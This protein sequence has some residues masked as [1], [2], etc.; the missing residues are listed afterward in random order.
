MTGNLAAR[1]RRS[2]AMARFS[3]SRLKWR[4]LNWGKACIEHPGRSWM[5]ELPEAKALRSMEGVFFTEYWACCVGGERPKRQALLHN[6]A[7]LH[8]LLHLPI[9]PGHVGLKTFEIHEDAAGSLTFDTEAEAE[10]PALLCELAAS[11]V[12]QDLAELQ[13]QALPA[14]PSNQP[15]WLHA[16]LLASTK[17]LG[18]AAVRQQVVPKLLQVVAG[19][20]RGREQQHLAE[21]LR[22]ADCRGSDARL[23]TGTLVDGSRQP[24]PYPAPAWAWETVLSWA[25]KQSA[26][27]NLLEFAAFLTYVRSRASSPTFHRQRFVHVFDSR[28]VS[29]VVA[30]GRSSSKRL[31]RLCRRYGALALACDVY[32]LCL[33]SISHWNY[34]DTGSRAIIADG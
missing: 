13:Q 1:V 31:N 6:S 2:N 5:W 8:A 7:R 22:H 32:V 18:Q 33:W 11:V 9:C 21:L 28:V 26:H 19:M 30:K 4:V 12:A 27:I 17:K 34:A 23:D 24:V 20:E 25:W 29:C 16:A 3:L 10:Y 15:G 14:A